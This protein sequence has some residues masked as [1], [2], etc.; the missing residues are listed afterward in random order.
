MAE[1]FNEAPTITQEA[2]HP[3]LL[4]ELHPSEEYTRGWAQGAAV[5]SKTLLG[6]GTEARLLTINGLALVRCN[7]GVIEMTEKD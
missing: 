4:H 2:H 5:L 6:D 7:L 3:A 1:R